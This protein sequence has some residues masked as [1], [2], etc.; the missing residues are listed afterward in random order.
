MVTAVFVVLVLV[1][2]LMLVPATPLLDPLAASQQL[3]STSTHARTASS[4]L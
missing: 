1:L 3:R 4:G 2:R